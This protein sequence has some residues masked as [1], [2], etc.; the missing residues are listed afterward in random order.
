MANPVLLCTKNPSF[1]VS[2]TTKKKTKNKNKQTKNLQS[3]F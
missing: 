3:L 1:K 2:Y